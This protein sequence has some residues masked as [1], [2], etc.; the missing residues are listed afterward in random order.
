MPR[1]TPLLW[2]RGVGGRGVGGRGGWQRL[3]RVSA[4]KCG[5]TESVWRE[6]EARMG[7]VVCVKRRIIRQAGT[8]VLRLCS[9]APVFK[10]VWG[11]GAG[12]GGG[13]ADHRDL[14]VRFL[15]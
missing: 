10:R 7:V 14:P 1:V 13:G 15:P 9:A 4:G 3:S 8:Y 5:A 12:R 11:G 2:L 6:G